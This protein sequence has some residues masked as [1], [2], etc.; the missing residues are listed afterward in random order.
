MKTWDEVKDELGLNDPE[1][2]RLSTLEASV[3]R[4]KKGRKKTMYKL[5]NKTIEAMN[6]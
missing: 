4:Q 5:V 6:K 1:I 2:E 3:Y